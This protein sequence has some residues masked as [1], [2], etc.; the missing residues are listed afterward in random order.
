M[1]D[2]SDYDW[3]KPVARDAVDYAFDFAKSAASAATIELW[4]PPPYDVARFR[5][6]A[7]IGGVTSAL[8]GLLVPYL[9][10]GKLIGSV[11]IGAK[12]L[13]S[14]GR[15]AG[16][17]HSAVRSAVQMEVARFLPF[18][19]AR[20]GVA[21]IDPKG[22]V[23]ETVG[24][25]VLDLGLFGGVTGGLALIRSAGPRL[26]RHLTPLAK[27][28]D[29]YAPLQIQQ[30]QAANAINL[31]QVAPAD[32]AMVAEKLKDYGRAVRMAPLTN[33]DLLSSGS[34]SAKPV[35]G[36]FISE[37]EYGP[38]RRSLE[39]LFNVGGKNVERRALFTAGTPT[40]RAFRSKQDWV[41][42]LSQGGLT[43]TDAE[44]Y[45]QYPRHL[46][47]ATNQGKKDVM[48]ALDDMQ[49][50]GDTFIAKERNA[51]LFVMAK[52]IVDGGKRGVTKGGVPETAGLGDEF[53]LFK[54]DTASRFMP[55]QF[56]K[57]ADRFTTR[58]A[59]VW[60]P[61]PENVD[62]VAFK[63]IRKLQEEIPFTKY[64]DDVAMGRIGTK[65]QQGLRAAGLEGT[66][67]GQATSE[68]AKAY[69]APTQ[70]QFRSNL[71][72][73]W[74]WDTARSG[75]DAG[76]ARSQEFLFGR[77]LR[78]AG[79]PSGS[80]YKTVFTATETGGVTQE[81]LKLS[82]DELRQF[83]KV[84][85]VKM[86]A[87]DASSS[88]YS[89]KVVALTER[90]RVYEDILEAE[91]QSL[92]KVNMGRRRVAMTSDFTRTLSG[93]YRARVYNEE[94]RAIFIGSGR[95]ANDAVKEANE[96][97][98]E[99]NRQGKTWR[100]DKTA[101]ASDEITDVT[102][103]GETIAYGT[104]DFNT[105]RLIRADLRTE[106]PW[107]AK[108]LN[109]VLKGQFIQAER[110][111]AD[112]SV[113]HLVSD[114]L[115]N[116]AKYDPP[117]GRNL[118]KRFE[119]LGG[120]QG[121]GTKAI[122]RYADVA[123]APIFG[124]N[125][126]TK[127]VNAVN[128][129]TFHLQFGM[130]NVGFT[131]LNLMQTIQTV[132]PRISFELN[133]SIA[134]RQ[135]YNMILPALNAAGQTKGT[136]GVLSPLKI[137]WRGFQAMGK[138]QSVKGLPAAIDRAAIDG[139]I[140]PRFVEEAIGDTAITRANI[141]EA[142]KQSPWQGFLAISQAGPTMSEKF[143]RAHAFT[144]S[145]AMARE[146]MGITSDELSYHFAKQFTEQ[147]MFQYA[148]ADRAL[149]MTGPIGSLW[150]QWKNFL[151]HQLGW[152]MVYADEAVMKGNWAPLLWSL[153]GT[154]A[155]AGVGGLPLYIAADAFARWGTDKGVFEH[156]YEMFD[157]AN[158]AN[159]FE[160]GVFYGLPGFFGVSLQAS[161]AAP[162]NDPAE[163]A[164]FLFGFPI[165]NRG[166]AAGRMVGS[167]IDQWSNTGTHPIDNP[168]V[169]DS[170]FRAFAPKT[171]YRAMASTEE[172]YIRSL[173]TG[174]V[175]VA[176]LTTA[177][178][179]GYILGLDP[180]KVDRTW[181]SARV[182]WR[183][184]DQRKANI[185]TLARRFSEARQ[186]NDGRE[187]G[188]VQREALAVG[189]LPEVLRRAHN[190]QV[191]VAEKQGVLERSFE[192]EEILRFPLNR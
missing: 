117:T 68:A 81:V 66:R 168:E 113:K 27:G 155:T 106:A 63:A 87:A 33:K 78:P 178:Q 48:A 61:E 126:A 153:G 88:G 108:E 107:T 94:G 1:A 60:R 124:R 80:V 189:I 156:V 138:P 43:Q 134:S 25:A 137:S 176:G 190:D 144:T 23:S 96:I 116:I 97:V 167:A 129:G 121:P 46:R 30:R 133:A 174:K 11:P 161:G 2:R 75:F 98:V 125:S 15:F 24:S 56:A 28:V 110:D 22:S 143:V 181:E 62:T 5:R 146:Y 19:A 49:W 135:K 109:G 12:Y 9:G 29:P 45:M 99:A 40:D 84:F 159:R 72:A 73:Q 59:R 55:A 8:S 34:L 105:A 145:Y 157:P 187:M 141:R 163:E 177:Q 67:A 4:R 185:T 170:F 188:Q 179:Y 50:F 76:A 51:G 175:N 162:M 93:P 119:Q 14:A 90:M 158:R 64:A 85:D 37:M 149:M 191:S 132:L 139:T 36:R 6:E 166:I 192:P 32:M 89:P 184:E 182:L 38:D 152:T 183:E 115:A 54:T 41:T 79:Q 95:N 69:L 74:V 114:R 101:W 103:L 120:R 58:T 3:F 77:S 122:N 131:A 160:D 82:D 18:E 7:P 52:R 154:W 39:R 180:T 186:T 171:L 123:L 57:L 53:L 140:A 151:M 142:F 164:S 173:T 20:V 47:V 112:L 169:R 91:R 16:A 111:L 136:I 44:V 65:V 150:G 17:E 70:F 118:H 147:T 13:Q 71:E 31:N 10:W 92:A 148:T 128:S 127:I 104:D 86:T 83:A 165:L 21:A 130:G 102:T 35:G 26:A 172:G 100:A 42:K